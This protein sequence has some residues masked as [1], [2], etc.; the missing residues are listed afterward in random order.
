MFSFSS[1]HVVATVACSILCVILLDFLHVI[2]GFDYISWCNYAYVEN[3]KLVAPNTCL[4]SYSSK[5]SQKIYSGYGDATTCT[6]QDYVGN[7][8]YYRKD[9]F[10]F[11]CS[12]VITNDDNYN[13]LSADLLVLVTQ[14]F[15]TKYT[16]VCNL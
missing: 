11:N 4:S 7:E 6:C 16:I 8:I 3:N 12:H 15:K 2:D 9:G 10:D 13:L 5:T 14:Q 1:C